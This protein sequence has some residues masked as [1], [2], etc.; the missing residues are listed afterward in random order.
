M[1]KMMGS[2]PAD[3]VSLPSEVSRWWC[4]GRWLNVQYMDM[5]QMLKISRAD[6]F[7]SDDIFDRMGE[8]RQ[9]NPKKNKMDLACILSSRH[10]WF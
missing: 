3:L 7:P 8:R 1:V 9:D 6:K 2:H 4:Q 5:E 10:W